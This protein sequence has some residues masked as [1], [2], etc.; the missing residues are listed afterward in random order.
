VRGVGV[1]IKKRKGVGVGVLLGVTVGVSVRVGVLVTVGVGPVAVGKGPY[2]ARD[3]R[4]MAVL[5][6]FDLAKTSNPST[7][8]RLNVIT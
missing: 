3:V 1:S 5:V 8:G 4:A 7:D 6:P 2:S